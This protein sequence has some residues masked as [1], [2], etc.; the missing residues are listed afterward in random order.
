MRYYKQSRN[1]L[2]YESVRGEVRILCKFHTIL[3]KDLRIPDIWYGGLGF[4]P[5]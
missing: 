3:Y 5:Q 2:K 4:N 1:D